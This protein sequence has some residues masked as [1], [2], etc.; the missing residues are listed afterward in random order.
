MKISHSSQ[1][2]FT[3]SAQVNQSCESPHF[4]PTTVKVWKGFLVTCE[5]EEGLG[6]AI[7]KSK[8]EYAKLANSVAWLE[9]IRGEVGADINIIY[10]LGGLF[11][12]GRRLVPQTECLLN[13]NK[14]Q[15]TTGVRLGGI[16]FKSKLLI[17]A[18]CWCGQPYIYFHVE[19]R[20]S[21]PLVYK[22]FGEGQG[23][24]ESHSVRMQTTAEVTAT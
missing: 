9:W 23:R 11:W 8:C 3:A 22:H 7:K 14:H 1:S 4:P 15:G 13:C 19:T 2:N 16:Y 21:S 12:V 24:K 6:Q 10:L 5:T 17:H 20:W 18:K